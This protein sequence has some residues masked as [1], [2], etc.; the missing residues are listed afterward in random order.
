MIT[1]AFHF[2]ILQRYT[3]IF[4]E[5]AERLIDMWGKDA[6]EGK[7]VDI[8]NNITTSALGLFFLTFDH[9]L[10][11]ISFYLYYLKI[12]LE[13]ALLDMISKHWKKEKIDI[14]MLELFMPALI[15]FMIALSN[16]SFTLT[17]FIIKLKEEKHTP[18]L[19]TQ[20]T[21]FVFSHRNLYF[22]SPI[23]QSIY[24]LQF[25]DR[26]VAERRVALSS[27]SGKDLLESGQKLDFVDILLTSKDENGNDLSDKE[28]RDECNTF[29][30]EGHGIDHSFFFFSLIE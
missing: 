1:P 16:P 5:H 26:V 22:N 27:E 6:D 19:A 7:V 25:A 30:F 9:L 18:P 24:Q 4:A 28:I 2:N 20:S 3:P 11:K 10:S 15:S 17:S 8:V 12:L 14:L 29:I 21:R 13:N 23:D